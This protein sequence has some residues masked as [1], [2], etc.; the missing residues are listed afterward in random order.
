MASSKQ[1]SAGILLFYK[2]KNEWKFFLVHPG[3]PFWKKKDVGAWSIPKGELAEGED[4]LSAARR[5]F[6]EE[7]G[8][9]ING[10]FIPLSSI[11]QKGGK[12]VLAWALETHVDETKLKSNLFEMEWPPHSGRMQQFPEVDSAKWFTPTEAKEKMNSGQFPLITELIEKLKLQ[13]Q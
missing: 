1:K 9:E 6:N 2:F 12:E 4:P 3:G 5:E 10:D 7:T 8:F 11:K 13:T